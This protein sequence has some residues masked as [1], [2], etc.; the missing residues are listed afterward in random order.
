MTD[1]K[2]LCI[3]RLNKDE[4]SHAAR[5]FNTEVIYEGVEDVPIVSSGFPEYE[6]AKDVERLITRTFGRAVARYAERFA[7]GASNIWIT[8]GHEIVGIVR[9]RP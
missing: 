6:E 9:V 2:H 4:L 7:N 8:Q 1:A 3:R 5:H